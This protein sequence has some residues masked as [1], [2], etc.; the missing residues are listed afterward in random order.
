MPLTESSA[1]TPPASLARRFVAA[2]VF[3]VISSGMGLLLRL[4]VFVPWAPLPYGH[5]L[6]AHSHVAFLGWVFNAFFVVALRHFLPVGSGRRLGRLWWVLQV[7][8]L[9][10]LISFP[11]QG[12]G[13]V[14]IAFSTLHVGA[15]AVFAWRL[16]RETTATAAARFHL[17]AALVFLL[18]SAA[19][20]VALGPLAAAG[21]R[22]APAYTLAVY[23]YL[24]CQYNGWFVF[25]LQALALERRAGD[26]HTGDPAAAVRA[27]RWLFA[28]S[29]LSYALS[30]L[31]SEPPALV[32]LVA[33]LGGAAQLIGALLL[34]RVLA[35]PSLRTA[36]NR[37]PLLAIAAGAWLL[38]TL[39]QFA[40]VLPGLLTLAH[41][42]F[43]AIAFLHLVFLGLVIPALVAWADD[44]GWFAPGLTRRVGLGLFLAGAALTEA[45]LVA[46]AVASLA[47]WPLGIPLAEGL[48]AGAV[49]TAAG[50]GVMGLALRGRGRTG[51]SR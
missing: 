36:V 26:G 7:S 17:R 18:L 25:F 30:T 3:L 16:W 9:G 48:L 15:S 29:L 27:G 24:H 22:D 33:G 49:G 28:G 41:Q 1:A 12:Y 42:R 45:L 47:G 2:W 5:L 43:V 19:G 31:W 40:A 46:P 8:V 32:H 44:A 23:W 20:P 39:L 10:M 4:Q 37:H 34:A 11:L 6:H 50:L 13:P 38:K 14:S 35:G 21:L 51:D